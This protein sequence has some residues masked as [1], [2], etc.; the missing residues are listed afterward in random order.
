M[1]SFCISARTLLLGR[2]E[3]VREQPIGTRVF[4]RA[5]D[6]NLNED[7]I[8][9][10]EARELRKRLETYFAGEGRNEPLLIEVPKGAY[11]PVFK[12][13]EQPADAVEPVDPGAR[14]RGSSNGRQTRATR[15]VD[16]ACCWGAWGS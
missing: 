10:V 13:R 15:L 4:G 16:A 2:L 11:V 14:R 6:Y 5:P 8:V 9:R 3:N 7:N 1:L 12:L